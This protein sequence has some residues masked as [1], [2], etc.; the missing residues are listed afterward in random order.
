VKLAGVEGGEHAAFRDPP[1]YDPA[2]L[3]RNRIILAA[4]NTGSDLPTTSFRAARLHVQIA[5]DADAD[6]E[7]KLTVA[8]AADGSAV[9][10]ASASATL[11]TAPAPTSEGA[12][13]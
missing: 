5:G 1:Y 12:V 10:A 3:S 11:A 2:A 13:P 4:F 6:F 7:V 8:F 9:P